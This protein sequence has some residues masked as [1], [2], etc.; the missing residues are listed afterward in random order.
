MKIDMNCEDFIYTYKLEKGISNIKG[1]VK[2]LRDLEYPEYI[3][4]E[5]KRMIN[6]IVV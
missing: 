4:N 1:G 5:T 2:V 6:E 3:I